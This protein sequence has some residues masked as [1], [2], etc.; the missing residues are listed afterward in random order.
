MPVI[1]T[2]LAS[3]SPGPV[4]CSDL[5]V[6]SPGDARSVYDCPVVMKTRSILVDAGQEATVRWEIR[7]RNGE[8][9]DLS[10]CLDADSGEIKVRFQNALDDTAGN[11]IIE[12]TADV[13]EGTSGLVEFDLPEDL[14]AA[15]G[16]F[17]MQLGVFNADSKMVFVDSGLVSVERGM[18]G[19]D[20]ADGAGP[21]TIGEIRIQLRDFL[22]SNDLRDVVEFD[23]T[24]V[25]QAIVQPLMQW[26]ETPPPVGYV[27]PYSCPWR[28]HW[29]R[30]TCAILLRTAAAWYLRNKLQVAHGG[31]QDDDR[32]R[33]REYLELSMLYQKEWED[34]MAAKKREI[35]ISLAYG[36]IY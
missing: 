30:A 27:T 25:L 32:N 13:Y 10:S 21:I 6:V 15:P 9:V 26:N 7:D 23:D 34:F 3:S 19:R 36:S 12:T 29:L 35:N 28:F 20:S 5:I 18:F 17:R 11:R 14:V 2:P 31:A 24:E 1:L 33:N 16:I 4:S 8:A 22:V